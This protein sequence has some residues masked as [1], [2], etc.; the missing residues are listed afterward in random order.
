MP[1]PLRFILFPLAEDGGGG[2]D[3]EQ[4][5]PWTPVFYDSDQSLAQALF[6]SG[7][8]SPPVLCSGLALCG[9]CRVRILPGQQ[10]L[11]PL[12]D[13]EKLFSAEELALGLRLACRR[14]PEPGMRL[15]LAPESVPDSGPDSEPD[16]HRGQSR[17]LRIALAPEPARPLQDLEPHASPYA[18]PDASP[19]AVP[20]A[21]PDGEG[22][23][24]A[25]D[26]G[27]TSLQW[28]LADSRGRTLAAGSRINPQ[29]GAGSDVIARIAAA[30]SRAGLQRLYELSLGALQEIVEKLPLRPLRLC[31]AANP[32]M[33]AIALGLDPS[34]LAAAPYSLPEK[35]GRWFALPQLPP[36]WLPPQLSPFV[37]GDIS[38]GYAALT[39]QPQQGAE[40]LSGPLPD[41]GDPALTSPDDAPPGPESADPALASPPDGAG[42]PGPSASAPPRPPWLLADLGT[43]CEFLLI[44][45]PDRCLAASSPMGPA[46][47]GAGLR[48]GSEARPGAA[49]DF[50]LGPKGLETGVLDDRNRVVFYEPRTTPEL[51]GITGTGALALLHLLRQCG[52]MDDQG[53]FAP[54]SGSVK[55]EQGRFRSPS[56]NLMLRSLVLGRNRQGEAQLTLPGGLLLCAGDVE[57]L[58][59]VKAAFS[60]ALSRLLREAALPARELTAIYLAGA[61]GGHLRK[62]ALSSLG[63]LPPGLEERALAVGNAALQG[64]LL[65]GASAG[66]RK[67]LLDWSQKAR[68]LD[69]AAD[70]S[71]SAD[72]LRH[73]TFSWNCD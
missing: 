29:M 32:A 50:R 27:T 54:P 45:A 70:P 69:L 2:P 63:F 71:F 31:L 43:N 34:G 37:G 18:S 13:E 44:L 60:L 56:G 72:Y 1:A 23:V 19:D 28:L 21:S 16:P 65:L 12:P 4:D 35:G 7:A 58:L 61:L 40:A 68:T 48:R 62:E 17:S 66:E 49:A 73:M 57:E 67:R 59:K 3:P 5:S 24:L 55:D 41:P 8:V 38:A 33:S 53:R 15:E 36:L 42:S 11:P 47:E 64:A 30:G 39:A 51:A 22:P 26:F 52:I 14:K 20:D 6:L 9:R 46:L 25:L 10:A